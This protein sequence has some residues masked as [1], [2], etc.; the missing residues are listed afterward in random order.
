MAEK[1]FG[2]VC[3]RVREINGRDRGRENDTNRLR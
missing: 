3:K 2:V 1:K